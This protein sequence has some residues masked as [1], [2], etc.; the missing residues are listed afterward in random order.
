MRVTGAGGNDNGR[1]GIGTTVPSSKLEV[2]GTTTLSGDL[3]VKQNTIA[4]KSVV[5]ADSL[6]V[7]TN[8]F[9]GGRVGIGI[10]NPDV[11]LDV[12]GV[13]ETTSLL[14]CLNVITTS[15]R[16][17]KEQFKPVN[18]REVLAKV[19]RLPISEW[20]FKAHDNQPADGARHIGPVAQDFREAFALGHDDKHIATV[21]ADGVA[22]AAIQGLNELVENQRQAIAD[23]QNR[24]RELEQRLAGRLDAL[25]KIMENRTPQ[26]RP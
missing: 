4:L 10:Q 11:A 3:L 21:D 17:A 14:F 19:T 12:N 18:P 15:D 23:L 7:A 22:L 20:Q 16:N 1:V 26:N 13:I 24:N 6:S 8:V 2:V 9:V 5:V 25:E